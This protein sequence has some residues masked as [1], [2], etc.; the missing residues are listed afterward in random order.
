MSICEVPGQSEINSQ[1]KCLELELQN[2]DSGR[3]DEIKVDIDKEL[4]ERNRLNLELKRSDSDIQLAAKWQTIRTELNLAKT[5][6]DQKTL[7]LENLI[8]MRSKDIEKYL[9]SNVSAECMAKLLNDAMR[10]NMDKITKLVDREHEYLEKVAT[11]KSKLA[12]IEEQAEQVN[13]KRMLFNGRMLRSGLDTRKMKSVSEEYNMLCTKKSN[14]L[15]IKQDE[16]GFLVGIGMT[17]NKFIEKVESECK[18]PLC[19]RSFSRKSDCEDLIQEMKSEIDRVPTTQATLDDEIKSLRNEFEHVLS[20]RSSIEQL[21][22]CGLK[23]K[24]L[25]CASSEAESE[26]GVASSCLNDIT[27]ELNMVK[28]EGE[29][30]AKL[31]KDVNTIHNLADE[32]KIMKENITMLQSRLGEHASS[33]K[34]FGKL[35]IFAFKGP[36]VLDEVQFERKNFAK[37][38]NEVNKCLELK[39]AEIS[40]IERRRFEILNEIEQLKR[41]S[42]EITS[43]DQN[44][45]NLTERKIETER[46]LANIEYQLKQNQDKL[47]ILISDHANLSTQ[48]ESILNQNRLTSLDNA[49]TLS[50]IENL[51][52][53]VKES[54]LELEQSH[55]KTLPEMDRLNLESERLNEIIKSV[56]N[57]ID[58]Q[59]GCLEKH[60]VADV[61]FAQ[62]TR[63]IEDLQVICQKR[64]SLSMICIELDNFSE[65]ESD[66]KSLLNDENNCRNEYDK[67]CSQ[68]QRGQTKME[69]HAEQIKQCKKQLLDPSLINANEN[70]IECASNV[71]ACEMA[72]VDLDKLYI[73]LDR[74]ILSFHSVKMDEL[75]R[76]IRRLWRNTY[77]GSDIEYVE[78]RSEV[79]RQPGGI[80]RRR[81]YNYKVV[82]ICNGSVIEMRHRCSAGQ[83]VLAS[84]II[85]LALA[86]AFGTDCGIIALDEPTTNLDRE[87][88]ESLACSLI[89]L[90]ECRRAQKN[91]QLIIITHDEDFVQIL[92]RSQYVE[93]FYR[94]QKSCKNTS[95]IHRCTVEQLY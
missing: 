32:I 22:D 85:R 64:S 54:R 67:I 30:F 75:N 13:N 39:R 33:T 93:E 26:L 20:L 24:E 86:E 29:G 61:T 74:S 89:D 84:I 52:K 9:G 71:K 46:E 65:F 21:D 16:K 27:N 3:I 23:L 5:N 44:I 36:F 6:I 82:M 40:T 76:I 31:Q 4:K 83:K 25:E 7:Q 50:C 66:L 94:I 59:S 49:Q 92:G 14:E 38:L 10:L 12:M 90:V 69:M 47:G 41:Q 78:I 35:L 79:D 11:H 81:N 45:K 80:V 19:H 42:L 63:T 60:K 37:L 17:Y 91:F 2:L 28:K 56:E 18:C 73:A 95:T 8:N 88:I 87:N 68:H 53:F 57:D 62:E 48:R 58:F 15:R 43:N 1:I 51:F 70:F 77:R 72:C 55:S 34:T